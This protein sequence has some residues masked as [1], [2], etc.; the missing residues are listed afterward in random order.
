L[1]GTPTVHTYTAPVDK[2][3]LRVDIGSGVNK[4]SVELTSGSACGLDLIAV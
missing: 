2:S 1:A 4:V 3:A